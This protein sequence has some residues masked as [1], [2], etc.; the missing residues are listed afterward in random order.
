[1]EDSILHKAIGGTM[2]VS[3]LYG[4]GKTVLAMTAENPKLTV[5]ID[6]DQKS[7][8]RAEGLGVTY[9]TPDFDVDPVELDMEKLLVWFREVLDGLPEDKT[10]L[11]IDNGSML[12]DAFHV[13]VS[14]DPNRYG[15][16]P[17]NAA[18]GRFGG[19][20]PGVGRIWK[21]VMTFL[22]GKGYKLVI[23]CIHMSAVWAGGAP[24]DKFKAKGNK[25]LTELANLTLVLQRSI[26]PS[27]PP[28]AIVGKEA[29][30]LV[31]FQDGEFKVSMA[32]PPVIPKCTWKAIG[33]YID[34]AFDKKEYIKDEKPTPDELERYGEWLTKEQKKL[35]QT[36]ASNPEFS[37][38]EQEA[39]GIIAKG[40]GKFD[41]WEDVIR[42]A[43]SRKGYDGPEDVRSA[44]KA[45]YVDG[46]SFGDVYD[47]LPTK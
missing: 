41:S 45:F 9:Y 1:M 24:I 47:K 37:M 3:G 32:L 38:S 11:I 10:T 2:L 27:T 25:T 17:A 15:V 35:I 43:V 8:A 13:A 21:N 29:L 46:M 34:G 33:E 4:S 14:Q 20:H 7:K 40:G 18:S 16:K 31:T 6:L 22:Q 36:V 5:M 28:R 26:F 42:A 19:T 44:A 39:S 12:E 23:I 30:G